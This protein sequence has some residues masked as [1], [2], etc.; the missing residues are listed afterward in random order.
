MD[1][2]I[3]E[4]FVK[5]NSAADW[6]G[7]VLQHGHQ[8]FDIAAGAECFLRIGVEHDT[9]DVGALTPLDQFVLQAPGTSPMSRH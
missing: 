6:M 2:I 5:K 1:Q 4:I 3:D 8:R 7:T 9:D